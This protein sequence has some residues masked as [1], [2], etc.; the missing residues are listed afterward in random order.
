MLVTVD[1]VGRAAG[2][3]F[4]SVELA[5][6]FCAQMRSVD[7]ARPALQHQLP[8]RSGAERGACVFRQIQVQAEVDAAWFKTTSVELHQRLTAVRP[9]GSTHHATDG[10][11]P[12]R[13]GQQQCGLVDA[14]VQTVV[15]D[16]NAQAAWA[17][18]VAATVRD[19]LPSPRAAINGRIHWFVAVGCAAAL[20]HWAVVVALVSR[21]G[22]QPLA[23]NVAAWLIAFSVS[24]LGHRRLTF[25]DQAAPVGRSLRRFFLVSAGGFLVN[26]ASYALLLHWSA[27]RYDAVLAIVLVGVAGF[28]YWLGRHWAFLRSEA[29]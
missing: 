25:A 22:W 26:E 4:E 18:I 6:N 9:G 19:M 28:T 1:I 5:S 16:R 10:L 2:G 23:A 7:A 15:V 21:A 8:Q 29:P 14:G 12:A 3:A 17:A 11:H 13:L 24:Y 20:V 27:L